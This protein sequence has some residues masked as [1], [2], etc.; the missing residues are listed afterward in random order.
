MARVES[1]GISTVRSDVRIIHINKFGPGETNGTLIMAAGTRVA[2][3]QTKFEHVGTLDAGV[4][5]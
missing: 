4:G 1:D 5:A 3:V 2:V